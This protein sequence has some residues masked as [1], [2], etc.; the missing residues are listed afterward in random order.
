M[1]HFNASV[2]IANDDDRAA[3]HMSAQIIAGLLDLALMPKIEPGHA[4]D[5][6]QF[7]LEDFRI[8]IYSA[9]DAGGLDVFFDLLGQLS[10]HWSLR[11][12]SAR[13]AKALND[14]G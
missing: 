5:I 12:Y 13:A 8:G 9:V 10:G 1:N 14:T 4:K 7:K 11:I 3:T 2:V 6:L